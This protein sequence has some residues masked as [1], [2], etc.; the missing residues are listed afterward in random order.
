M[1]NLFLI[2][3]GLA[4]SISCTQ[5][6]KPAEQE[7]WLSLFNG[8]D[9]EGWT[10][11]I[12]GYPVGENFG[13]TFYVEDGLLKTDYKAYGDD[14]NERYGHIYT[15][16]GYSH[17]KLCLEY[18]FFGEHAPKAPGWS[19]LNNGIMLHAQSPESM[20]LD[21]PFPVSIEAQLLGTDETIT[22]TTGNVC[23]PGTDI[24][25]DGVPYTDHCA[26]SSSKNYPFD[27]WVKAEVLVLGDSIVH[28]IIEGDTVMTYT[29][30]TVDAGD[31]TPAIPSG[32]LKSGRIALQ[33]EGHPTEFR[34]IEL[35]DLSEK[36]QNK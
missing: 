13:N 15:N 23:T 4:L 19:Y 34:K 2:A 5:T 6:K 8:K 18:R 28:H 17:Y 12:S 25:L 16:N 7:K 21:Q 27:R 22:N 1:K 30:L 11:K 24:Y 26:S 31:M 33:S 3:M 9:L 20:L 14:F 36:Y 35:L 32:P 29:K 10:V